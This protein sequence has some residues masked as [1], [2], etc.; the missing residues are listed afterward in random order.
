VAVIASSADLRFALQMKQPPD[1]FEFR[2]DCLRDVVDQL[3][4]KL[5]SLRVPLIITARDPRE[6]GIGNLS[7]AK[8]CEL[9]SRFLP[10]AKYVDVE[11]RSARAFKPLLAQARKR[12]VGVILSLH[13][14][15]STPAPRALRVKARDAK[16]IGADIFKVATRT[17]TP[18]A[19][20]RL[21][22]F[23]T[24]KDLK[25][26]VSAMGIGKL[27]GLSRLL[28]ARCGSVLNYASFERPTVEGQLPIELLRSALS[29]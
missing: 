3:E 6:G 7:F 13:D 22:D 11:L 12:N 21:V 27:G 26:R 16:S 19:L 20:A 2:L 5:S 17:D 8:R 28:L 14:F 24:N 9:L 25:L 23:I 15:Q 29:R 18:A 4:C 10:R 1:L